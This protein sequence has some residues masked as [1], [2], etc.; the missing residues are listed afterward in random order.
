MIICRGTNDT[1][2]RTNGQLFTSLFRDKLSLQGA[3][4]VQSIKP[5]RLPSMDP[6]PVVPVAVA[7][8]PGRAAIAPATPAVW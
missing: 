6:D 3:C 7:P 8:A 1:D 2:G 5:V 4:I